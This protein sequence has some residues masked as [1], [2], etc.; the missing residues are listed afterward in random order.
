MDRWRPLLGL[1]LDSILWQFRAVGDR[2][3]QSF[4]C[5]S[6]SY[7]AFTVYLFVSKS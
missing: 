2:V 1:Q 7:G 5:G 6:P 4:F 3:A